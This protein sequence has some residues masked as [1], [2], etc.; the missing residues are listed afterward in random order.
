M[1]TLIC[2]VLVVAQL[3]AVWAFVPAAFVQ[4]TRQRL[5]TISPTAASI[6]ASTEPISDTASLSFD[7]PPARNEAEA[8]L[9]AASLTPLQ[10]FGRALSFYSAAVPLFVSYKSLKFVID[11]KRDTLGD[12]ISEEEENKLYENIHEWGSEQIVQKINELKGFY[13]KTGQIISTRVD[14]F[15]KQYT[16]KLAITQDKLDPLPAS[17]VKDVVRR[18]LLNGAEL[19][20]LF[21]EFDE[22]PLGSASIAQ[23]HRA[24]LLDGRAVA[25]K[26]QRPGIGAK[27]L[28]D[29]ANLKNFAKLIGNALFLDYYKIFSELERTLVYEL[30]FLHEAM[31]ANKVAAAVAHSPAN[32]LQRPPVKVPLPIPG[33]VTK[34]VLV[35]EYIDGKALSQLAAEMSQR[36][37]AAGSAE[38]KL[39]GGKLLSALTDAYGRMIFGSGIIHGDPHPYVNRAPLFSS[40]RYLSKCFVH[41]S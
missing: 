33:L 35:M 32:K 34:H 20:E 29:I 36:G 14:I 37:V 40:L 7:R 27:L 21:L 38:S 41:V 13:V 1:G 26:V 22:V 8:N 39:L 18:E 23:V 25:V 3:C 5:S 24:R 16:S 11:F 17:V 30:D 28:G 2:F 4:Q 19:G 9:N 12:K 31:S 15:P 6:L 10:R